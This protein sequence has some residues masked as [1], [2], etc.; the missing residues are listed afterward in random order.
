M[1][2]QF[3]K[4]PNTS[5]A[6]DETVQETIKRHNTL[7]YIKS[8][9]FHSGEVISI[10]KQ[11]LNKKPPGPHGILNC[12]L[13]RF[14][15]RP[16]L[17]NCQ[18]PNRCAHLEYFPIAWKQAYVIMIQKLK[19]N[20]LLKLFESLLLNH[21]KTYTTSKIRSE[22]YSFRLNLP[23]SNRWTHYQRQYKSFHRCGFSQCRK[24]VR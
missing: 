24:G 7:F 10:I 4:P 5:T 9:F 1:E 14:G 2:A 6:I 21:L 11:L 8:I 13:K 3:Q 18:I 23:Q 17:H 22:K 20:S 15:P 12:T 19:R 16:I